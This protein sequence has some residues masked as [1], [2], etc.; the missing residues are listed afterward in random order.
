MP[1]MGETEII[2]CLSG[3]RNIV[4]RIDSEKKF[5][6]DLHGRHYY[7]LW[8]KPFAHNTN[9]A[10]SLFFNCVE[11]TMEFVFDYWDDNILDK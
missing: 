1:T 10:Q 9:H 11:T 6:A 5:D 2:L 4:K 7:G 3:F 8:V